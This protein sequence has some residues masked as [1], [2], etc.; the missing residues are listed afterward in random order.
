MSWTK[1]MNVGRA[2]MTG[3]TEF[4]HLFRSC[5]GG[6]TNQFPFLLRLTTGAKIQRTFF[7]NLHSRGERGR[8]GRECEFQNNAHR[9]FDQIN[10]FSPLWLTLIMINL[11]LGFDRVLDYLLCH[12]LA[13]LWYVGH[14]PGVGSA[15]LLPKEVIGSLGQTDRGWP[16]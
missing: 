6:C 15:W 14:W 11:S 10:N 9:T 1:S 8:K 7:W 3:Q 2:D 5:W 4:V 12:I 16:G 13:C